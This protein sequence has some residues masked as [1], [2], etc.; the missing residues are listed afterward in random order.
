MRKYAFRFLCVLLL[1]L[2]F[3]L[4]P[5]SSKEVLAPTQHIATGAYKAE[6]V[7]TG[8]GE[9]TTAGLS[10]LTDV[11]ALIDSGALLAVIAAAVS[12]E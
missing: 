7:G 12:G 3:V 11:E 6:S 2:A 5:L 4:G 10:R 1:L 8:S 9:E